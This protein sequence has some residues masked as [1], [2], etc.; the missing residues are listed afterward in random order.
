MAPYRAG[1]LYFHGAASPTEAVVPVLVARLNTAEQVVRG[2]VTVALSYK[3][4]ARRITTGV[5][6]I[7]I[8]V[9]SDDMFSQGWQPSP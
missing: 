5:P 6:V 9:Q 2:K 1:H 7:D 4:G 3:K 8:Q